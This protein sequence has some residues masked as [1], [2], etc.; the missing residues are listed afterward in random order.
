MDWGFDSSYRM[1]QLSKNDI[2]IKPYYLCDNRSSAKNELDAISAITADI[3]V[4]PETKCN[5]LPLIQVKVTDIDTDAAITE[6]YYRLRKDVLIGSQY[7]WLARFAKT[8]RGYELCL[9]KSAIAHASK[10]IQT[11]GNLKLITEGNISYYIVDKEK[12]SSDLIQIFGE[13]HFPLPLYE[14]TKLETI[15]EYR[16]LGFEKSMLKTWFCHHPINNEPCG[17]CN[18]CKTVIEEGLSFRLSQAGLK[19]H[20]TEIKYGSYKWYS[21]LKK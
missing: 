21:L 18:P 16:K 4:H 15:E 20:N 1:V 3:K 7:D 8:H 6:A 14:I 2:T 11:N 19:R 10:C 9:E 17:L 12:S 13:Y 5:I